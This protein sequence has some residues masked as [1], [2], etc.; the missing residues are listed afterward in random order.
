[1]RIEFEQ[2]KELPEDYKKILGELESKG[3]E[4]DDLL[5]GVYDAFDIFEDSETLVKKAIEKIKDE[6]E[7][8]A[9]KRPRDYIDIK[10]YFGWEIQVQDFVHDFLY[11]LASYFKPVH[12]E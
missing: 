6:L 11:D 10:G 4:I 12:E 5:L 8:L 9:I 7:T 2:I 3:Y 1:M